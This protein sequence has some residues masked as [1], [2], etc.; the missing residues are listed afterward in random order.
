M[1]GDQVWVVPV[2]LTDQHGLSDRDWYLDRSIQVL[3]R[4]HSQMVSKLKDAYSGSGGQFGTLAVG[5]TVIWSERRSQEQYHRG[6]VMDMG[7]GNNIVT[8][9]LSD[10]GKLKEVEYSSLRVCPA[11]LCCFPARAV[12]LRLGSSGTMALVRRERVV[13]VTVLRGDMSAHLRSVGGGMC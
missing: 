10:S 8:I 7:A 1:Q 5:Q 9:F 6:V 3:D 4:L 2:P 11:E 13:L 12:R